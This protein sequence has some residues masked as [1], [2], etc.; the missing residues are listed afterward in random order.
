MTSRQ[1]AVILSVLRALPGPEWQDDCDVVYSLVLA[2][3]P[4]NYATALTK[5]IVFRC[6]M[7]PSPAEVRSLF[8]ELWYPVPG[9]EEAWAMMPRDEAET[10][11]WTAE[12]QEA[13]AI[14]SPLLEAGDRVAA[15]MAFIESYRKA[16]EAAT[17]EGKRPR[18]SVSLGTNKSDHAAVLAEAIRKGRLT[19]ERVNRAFPHLVGEEPIQSLL[20]AGSPLALPA[21]EPDK[22]AIAQ[23]AQ[24][25]AANRSIDGRRS[26]K[27]GKNGET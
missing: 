21:G 17:R 23:L 27:D 10:V 25:V 8:L 4:D 13:F 22:Q 2:D 20:P 16:V 12:M 7:R 15:R 24:R 5:E 19:V 18:W 1:Q 11:V 3:I 26:M 9:P 6:R 14:A